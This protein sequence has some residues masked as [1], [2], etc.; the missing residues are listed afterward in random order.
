MSKDNDAYEYLPRTVLAWPDPD[1]FMAEMEEEGLVDC[2]Y[3][4]LTQ[5]IACLHWG[6]VAPGRNIGAEKPSA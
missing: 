6:T 4:R 1:R 5:G 2:G 3:A